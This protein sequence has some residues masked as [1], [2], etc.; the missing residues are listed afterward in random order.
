MGW[1][2]GV[3]ACCAGLFDKVEEEVCMG[4]VVEVVVA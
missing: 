1:G 2:V 3:G 4:F